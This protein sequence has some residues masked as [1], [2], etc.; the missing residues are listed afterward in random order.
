MDKLSFL[1]TYPYVYLLLAMLIWFLA[2]IE[3][4]TGGALTRWRVVRRDEQ[5]KSFRA[6]V[7]MHI[8]GGVFFIGCFLFRFYRH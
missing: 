4:C 7:L 8:F 1:V 6:A 3:T 5:P 2:V